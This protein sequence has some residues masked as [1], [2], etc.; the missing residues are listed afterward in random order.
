M[1]TVEIKPWGRSELATL[2]DEY[3]RQPDKITGDVTWWRMVLGT[4]VENGSP[5]ASAGDFQRFCAVTE[6][7][8]MWCAGRIDAGPLGEAGELAMSLCA[9]N[10]DPPDAGTIR[11]THS[12]ALWTTRQILNLAES[13]STAKLVKPK[14]K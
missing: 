13:T 7:L 11:A 14:R 10:D 9:A 1:G 2:L 5:P 4:A 12:R 8:A 3:Q 6:A